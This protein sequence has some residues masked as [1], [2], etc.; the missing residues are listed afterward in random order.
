MPKAENTVTL[1]EVTI[2]PASS[3]LLIPI[4]NE[5]DAKKR[6]KFDKLLLEVTLVPFGVALKTC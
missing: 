5:V 3:S 6:I 4:L 1:D 2:E